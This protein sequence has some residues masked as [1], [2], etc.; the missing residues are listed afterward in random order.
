M[1]ELG[2]NGGGD[3]EGKLGAWRRP[4]IGG[5]SSLVMQASLGKVAILF[6]EAVTL[7]ECRLVYAACLPACQLSVFF[8]PSFRF[9]LR[10]S[11]LPLS[12]PEAYLVP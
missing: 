12:L 2:G 5:H 9:D 1:S 4:S 7:L 3:D 6:R 11:S 10:S 8:V